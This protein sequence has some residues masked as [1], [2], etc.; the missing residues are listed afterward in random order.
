MVWQYLLITSVDGKSPRWHPYTPQASSKLDSLFAHAHATRSKRTT[1]HVLSGTYQYE[2]NMLTMTQ[3]NIT[4]GKLRPIRRCLQSVI[5]SDASEPKK[6]KPKL[7]SSLQLSHLFAGLHG[8]VWEPVLLPLIETLPD[9]ADYLA[10]YRHSAILPLRQLTFQALK[11]NLPVD[12]K[13]IVFGQNPVRTSIPSFCHLLSY[14]TPHRYED[15][16]TTIVHPQYPRVESATGIA[17]F[18]AQLDDWNHAKFGTIL[19]MRNLIKSAAMTKYN[20]S[21]ATKVAQLRHILAQNKVITPSQWFQAILAQGV[22]LL[23]ASLTIGGGK[24]ASQHTT[25]WRPVIKKIVEHILLQKQALPPSDGRRGLLFLW[26]GRQALATK[27]RLS[28][29]LSRY[30]HLPVR[31]LEWWNPASQRNEFC[32]S[33]HLSDVNQQLNQMG[34]P[35]I[36]WLP[37]EQWLKENNDSI[38]VFTNFVTDTKKLH[39]MYLERLQTGLELQ[40]NNTPITGIKGLVVQGLVE[41]VAPFGVEGAAENILGIVRGK[42]CGNLS[43]S[44]KGAIYMYTTGCLYHRLN[45]A[46]RTSTREGLVCFLQYLKLF[47]LAHD[48]LDET[49]W[50][51]LYRGA[52]ADLSDQYEVGSI[53]TWWSI[54]S[55]SCNPEIAH[56][57]SGR[58]GT[59][60]HVKAK[61]ATSIALLSA[62]QGEEEFVLAPGTQLK[63]LK[64]EKGKGVNEVYL[65]EVIASRLVC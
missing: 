51:D 11:P 36:N 34:M 41:A 44:E 53:V 35:Q 4:T 25:F 65:E 23:N 3:R 19:S 32:S 62:Y 38:S 6:K 12:W 50:V 15:V 1:F 30:L 40:A 57:F 48:K 22:L 46:L 56:S 63:A 55:C 20:T 26:W 60:F 49:D 29:V 33:T 18:D 14:E 27:R 2:V 64:R 17:L 9:A 39:A 59:L 16:L 21:N 47:L 24:K 42:H 5:S 54:S 52:S 43:D 61:R 13:V 45:M 7:S 31:H 10:P 8:H 37:D 58:N 28:T